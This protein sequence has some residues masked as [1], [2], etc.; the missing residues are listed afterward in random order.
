MLNKV[1]NQKSMLSLKSKMLSRTGANPVP[2]SAR[3]FSQVI[4]G[5]EGSTGSSL[6]GNYT[7]IDHEYDAIVLGAGGAG[8][9]RARAIRC[10]LQRVLLPQHA[11][12]C[13]SRACR[14][15]SATDWGASRVIHGR[16]LQCTVVIG[17]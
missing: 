8:L 2:I 10:D 12:A 14:R 13:R 6:I 16:T 4:G 11:F 7:V 17:L 9:E 5:S 3:K 15:A 1:F